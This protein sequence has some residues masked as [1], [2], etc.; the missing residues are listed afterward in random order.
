MDYNN[1]AKI[2]STICS[3]DAPITLTQEQTY[4]IN[5][6]IQE[7]LKTSVYNGIVQAFTDKIFTSNDLKTKK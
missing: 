3:V 6:E 4:I 1:E 7:I 5:K 2:D